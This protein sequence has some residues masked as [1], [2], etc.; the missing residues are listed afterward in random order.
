MGFTAS[1]VGKYYDLA[2]LIRSLM[3]AESPERALALSSF[4]AF[5]AAAVSMLESSLSVSV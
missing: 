5:E 4:S 3:K 1:I 2:S